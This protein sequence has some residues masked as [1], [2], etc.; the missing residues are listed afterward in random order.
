MKKRIWLF[1]IVLL[2]L[3][4]MVGGGVLA[5]TGGNYDLSWHSI[6][7]GGGQATGGGYTLNGTVGQ[8]DAGQALTGGTYSLT[9]GFWLGGANSSPS[10]IK[11]YLPL[12]LK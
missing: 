4:L 10:G 12:V 9:G 2:A 1:L 11:V 8:A 3:G 6:D 5:Q 7:G